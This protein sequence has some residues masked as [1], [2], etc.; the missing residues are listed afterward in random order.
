M[1]ANQIIT[2]CYDYVTLTGAPN[3]SVNVAT[4]GNSS[5][6]YGFLRGIFCANETGTSSCTIYDD[7]AAGTAVK[8]IDTF[9]LAN[10]TFYS[11]PVKYKTGCNV[12]LS[13][14]GTASI[15]IFFN[16]P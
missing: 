6:G 10:A 16:R 1:P 15:T 3:G 11:L 7:P 13:G 4:V 12:V 5:P 2:D 8:I 14:T 9:V